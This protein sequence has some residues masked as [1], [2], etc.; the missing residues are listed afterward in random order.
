[1]ELALEVL[2]Q[3][4]SDVTYTQSAIRTVSEGTI[5][6]LD[7]FGFVV[8]S[9]QHT[10]NLI[11]QGPDKGKWEWDTGVHWARSPTANLCHNLRTLEPFLPFEIRVPIEMARTRSG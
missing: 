9:G 7:G 2:I 6:V 5:T 10:D 3:R 4:L 8:S 1:M 11:I